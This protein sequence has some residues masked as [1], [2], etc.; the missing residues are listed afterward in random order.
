M[1]VE[2]NKNY[3]TDNLYTIYDATVSTASK[4]I[5]SLLVGRAGFE[6]TTR[7]LSGI[8]DETVPTASEYASTTE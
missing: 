1:G 2:P 4:S 8:I 3:S 6:P 7:C 5:I